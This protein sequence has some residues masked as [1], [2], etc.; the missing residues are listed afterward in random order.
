MR[1][2]KRCR[3][4]TE[5]WPIHFQDGD[6]NL[7]KFEKCAKDFGKVWKTKICEEKLGNSGNFLN[8]CGNYENIIYGPH[9]KEFSVLE[10]L[11]IDKNDIDVSAM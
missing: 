8:V 6:K 2:V 4:R 3:K 1:D 5:N 7:G 10:E 11:V 9:S